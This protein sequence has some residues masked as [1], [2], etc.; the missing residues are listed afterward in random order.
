MP[1]F[2]ADHN[3]N[4]DILGGLT[5][6]GVK[7]DVLL[8]REVNL[9]EVGDGE[10]LAWAAHQGMVVLTHD[11]RTLVAAAHRR[12]RAG[13]T[14]PGVVAIPSQLSLVAAIESLATVAVCSRDTD[15]TNTILYLPL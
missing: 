13:E 9:Q 14:M 12:V 4:E 15:F 6:S 8:A 5:R 1:Q 2:L 10:L 7:I 11:V 3:F